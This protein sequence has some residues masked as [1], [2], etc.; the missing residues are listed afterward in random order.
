M[1]T[2]V[3]ERFEQ[4]F[5]KIE[6]HPELMNIVDQKILFLKENKKLH[7]TYISLLQE[8]CTLPISEI[9]E[10]FLQENEEGNLLRSISSPFFI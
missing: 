5:S 2:I 7:P 8:I 1:K 6:T 3:K 10:K 9:K 4:T